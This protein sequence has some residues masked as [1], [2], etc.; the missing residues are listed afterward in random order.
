[1]GIE[2]RLHTLEIAVVLLNSTIDRLIELQYAQIQ[3]Q[4]VV[5]PTGKNLKKHSPKKLTRD[6]LIDMAGRYERVKGEADFDIL[7]KVF[8]VERL[9]D[10]QKE[11]YARFYQQML[12]E[13]H[14]SLEE[15]K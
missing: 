2:Q 5:V 1:M 11:D 12:S 15:E 6:R 4:R 9:V 10:L 14:V 8:D 3:Q 7:L 13:L